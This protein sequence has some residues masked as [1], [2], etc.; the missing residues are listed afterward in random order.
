MTCACLCETTLKK[1][2]ACFFFGVGVGFVVWGSPLPSLVLSVLAFCCF[3]HAKL[4]NGL[5]VQAVPSGIH[6]APIAV[7]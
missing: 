5:P 6:A 2:A 4:E 1:C 3:A 7:L